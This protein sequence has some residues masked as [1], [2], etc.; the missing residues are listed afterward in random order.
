MSAALWQE[1]VNEGN[2]ALA[3]CS[4][5]EARACFEAALAVHESAQAREGL[6]WAAW[7]LD[8]AE[9]LF[10][11]RERA[12]QLYRERTDDLAAARMAMWLGTDYLDFRGEE[13]IS[14]GWRQLARRL[15]DE[16][17]TAPEHGFFAAFEGDIALL[18]DEDTEVARRWA[19]EAVAIGR[20]LR[21]ADVEVLGRTV[22]GLALVTEGDMAAGMS[23]LD[24]AAAA[25]LAGELRETWC[26]SL[27]L[28]HLIFACER[29]RD[30]ARAAQWCQYAREI[31]ERISFTFGQGVCRVHYAGVLLWR[32]KWLE[33]ENELLDV[34]RY[35]KQHRPPY[36]PEAL[37][38]LGELR[39][40]QGRLEEAAAF[41]DQSR[42][43]PLAGL[44]LAELALEEGR[45]QD[46]GECVQR[47]LRQVPEKSASQRVS[48][49]ELLSRV[50]A[51][52]GDLEHARETLDRLD[53]IVRVVGTQ[54]LLATAAALRGTLALAAGQMEGALRDFE[55]AAISFELCGNS[56]EA[57]H[58]RLNLAV[59]LGGL[60]RPQRSAR[61]AAA[62]LEVFLSLGAGADARRAGEVIAAT[63]GRSEP[64]GHESPLTGRQL[65]VLKLIARGMSDREIAVALVMSEHTVH[66]H[67]ANILQRLDRPS[68]AAAV[69][70]ASRR[71]L[72]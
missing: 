59:A 37:V 20:R 52:A 14:S 54:P 4:W 17:P 12:Y 42:S 53:S 16:V 21:V 1:R 44:G 33:A 27:V 9:T 13:A 8:D 50:Q 36:E 68:R 22:E 69:A 56:Y 55:D 31:A 60:G 66:R 45:L 41:F 7:W 28:C 67:V 34:A 58:A 40:R 64:R 11:A 24:G 46:A 2:A 6:S 63:E 18:I 26:A 5:A 43:H 19:Q 23:R 30:Y 65:E 71:G 35:L 62:A 25:A 39:R 48:A 70:E 51:A 29:T 38:R 49:L 57:A 32:G 15:L 47:V 72:L 3:R 10:A 61:E